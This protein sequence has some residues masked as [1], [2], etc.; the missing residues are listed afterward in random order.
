MKDKD[1]SLLTVLVVIIYLIIH[2]LFVQG[3]DHSITFK[4]D[5]SKIKEVKTIDR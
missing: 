5:T 2:I 1:I 4:E 3:I